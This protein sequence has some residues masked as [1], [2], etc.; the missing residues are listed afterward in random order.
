[1]FNY[2]ILIIIFLQ[3]FQNMPRREQKKCATDLLQSS[4]YVCPTVTSYYGIP[5][6]HPIGC[7][8]IS[9]NG[10]RMRRCYI[11]GPPWDHLGATR[12]RESQKLA[13][14]GHDWFFT[15]LEQPRIWVN[16]AQNCP[17]HSCSRRYFSHY[18]S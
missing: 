8:A 17:L 7:D 5:E 16:S 18:R 9:P 2:G 10:E 15:F 1:M 11:V 14:S 13:F 4:S 6:P 12:T 3:I